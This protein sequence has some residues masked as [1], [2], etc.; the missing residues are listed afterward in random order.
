MLRRALRSPHLLQDDCLSIGAGVTLNAQW[1]K[2]LGPQIDV[3]AQGSCQQAATQ[4]ERPAPFPFLRESLNAHKNN[5]PKQQW[6]PGERSARAQTGLC[7]ALHLACLLR[8]GFGATGPGSSCLPGAL[9]LLAVL[10]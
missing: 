2:K 7:C 10:S 1:R 3:R 9:G 6:T 8:I 5:G 4:A